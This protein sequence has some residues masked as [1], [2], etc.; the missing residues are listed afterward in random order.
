MADEKSP[1]NQGMYDG[2][3][4]LLG[5]EKLDALYSK[6]TLDR[7]NARIK[8]LADEAKVKKGAPSAG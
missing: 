6:E 5:D 4:E 3:I 8:K 7:M 1:L 2:E